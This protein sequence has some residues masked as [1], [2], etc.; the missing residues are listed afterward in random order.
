MFPT[1]SGVK[2]RMVADFVSLV[3]CAPPIGLSIDKC[4]RTQMSVKSASE[5]IV[6]KKRNDV[7][8]MLVQRIVKRQR[9]P[10][11]PHRAAS[12]CN[13]MAANPC[14]PLWSRAYAA[15]FSEITRQRRETTGSESIYSCGSDPVDQEI[16]I[17]V[18]P[19]P[20]FGW[21]RAFAC[22]MAS[23]LQCLDCW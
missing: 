8:Q 13:C 11:C 12:K 17:S 16:R 6:I 20:Q 4:L 1:V 22:G 21:G 7:I 10:T 19:V 5:T 9:N 14:G 15:I 18:L 23:R 2:D 3:C